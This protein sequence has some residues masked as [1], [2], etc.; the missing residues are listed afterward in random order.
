MRT[1]PRTRPNDFPSSHIQ[2][3]ESNDLGRAPRHSDG[4]FHLGA[5]TTIRRFFVCFQVVLALPLLAALPVPAL[6]E[7]V[8]PA[9]PRIE[10]FE[11]SIPELQAA[12][13]AGMVTSAELVDAYVARIRTFDQD[14]PSL[15]AILFLNPRAHGEALRLDEERARTGPRGP[16]HG[17]PVL[18]KDNL[19]T[20]DMPTTGGSFA[21]AGMHPPRD[22]HLVARL[23]EAGAIILGKTNMHE[24]SFG[25]TTLSSVDGQTLNPYDLEVNPGGSSGGTGVAVAA[26]FAAVGFGTDTCGSLRI[27]AAFNALFTLRPTKGLVSTAGIVPLARSLDMPGPLARTA[28]DLALALDA[29]V[30]YDP[31]DPA[32]A[33]L[34]GEPTLRFAAALDPEALSGARI[35]VLRDYLTPSMILEEVAALLDLEDPSAL[36][37]DPFAL[38]RI[39]AVQEEE[40]GA[41]M[42]RTM[43]QMQA[44]GA[45]LVEVRLPQIDSLLDAA[46]VVIDHEFRRD[47]EAY[48]AERPDA[49]FRTLDEIVAR[50]LYHPSVEAQLLRRAGHSTTDTDEY[51][52][53]RAQLEAV[54]TILL[55]VFQRENLDALVYPTMRRHA[56]TIG[57]T[58]WGSTCQLSTSSGF[59]ALTMPAG[60]TAQGSPVG[61]ELL[62]TPLQDA[63]L[64]AIAFALEQAA[65]ARRPPPTTP[66]VGDR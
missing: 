60:F 30:G 38:A 16:L 46:P 12:M 11:A 47:L 50:G 36:S 1:R 48:L 21:L 56:V 37:T 20:F 49:P 25:I 24:L 23:R 32:T 7:Q 9:Q 58:Q 59:P 35:G 26:S 34:E 3:V 61:L 66:P 17:I 39:G 19:D 53:A 5:E 14:G 40:I 42:G 54:R 44:L 45:T 55:E 6:S 62:G 41:I 51:R 4:A 28:T 64:V 57:Q 29:I 63:R 8:V 33:I 15:N 43:A 13:E 2:S 18:L 27:P 52:R 10:V 22:A 65:P 31:T